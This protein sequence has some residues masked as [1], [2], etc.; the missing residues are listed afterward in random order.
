MTVVVTGASGHVGANLVRALLAR[1]YQVRALVHHD[2]RAL[3]GLDV[4][5]VTGD[6]GSPES[7]AR[8]FAQAEVVYHAAGYISLLMKDW[9]L[10][11]EINV[12]G[13]RNVVDV[14]NAQNILYQAERDYANTR[15]DYILNLMRLKQQAGLLSPEDVFRLDTYLVPPAP[16]SATS[17]AATNSSGSMSGTGT[18]TQ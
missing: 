9:P 7:L 16:P 8:A 1:G 10:S 17:A 6:I 5:V 11:R 4:E 12:V 14:L 2:R 3:A 18:A 13:T 15:Y